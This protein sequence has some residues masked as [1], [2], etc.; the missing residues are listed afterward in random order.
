MAFNPFHRFRKHQKVW[1]AGLTIVCMIV[2][3]CTGFGGDVVSRFLGW[4]GANRSRGEVVTKLYGKEV[5]ESDLQD[6]ARQRTFANE[7]MR[8]AVFGGISQIRQELPKL[9]VSDPAF[10]DIIESVERRLQG[11]SDPRDFR[12]TLESNLSLFQRRIHEP[13]LPGEDPDSR[14]RVIESLATVLAEELWEQAVRQGKHRNEYYLGGFRRPASLLD[15][16]IWLHEAD[17]LGIVLTDA[18]VRRE[19]NR[20]AGNVGAQF[21]GKTFAED[22]RVRAFLGSQKNPNATPDKLMTALRDE[23]RVLL[24]QQAVLGQPGGQ[25][26]YRA[27]VLGVSVSPAVVTP[28]EYL[29]YFREQRTALKVAFLPVAVEHFLPEVKG[30]P[31]EQ[32]LENRYNEYKDREPAPSQR[33]P[34]FKIPRR[35]KYQYASVRMDSPFYQKEADLYLKYLDHLPHA[36]VAA[37]A[38][39]VVLGSP[40]GFAINASTPFAFDPIALSYE[41]YRSNLRF[42][43]S[44]D[45]GVGIDPRDKETR[46]ALT[47]GQMFAAGAA[48][49][50]PLA[51]PLAAPATRG[52]FDR[53]EVRAFATSVLAAG[54]RSPL[55]ALG[56]AMPALHVPQPYSV[57]R[58]RLRA[59]YQKDL[60]RTL[61]DQNLQALATEA[62]K[63]RNK[64]VEEAVKLMKEKCAQLHFSW[65]SMARPGSRYELDTDPALKPFR[66]AYEKD[67]EKAPNARDFASVLIKAPPSMEQVRKADLDKRRVDAMAISLM[68]QQKKP[69]FRLFQLAQQQKQEI[70]RRLQQGTEPGLFDVRV[71]PTGEG[72]HQE[73]FAFWRAEDRPAHVPSPGAARPEVIASWKFDQARALALR[74]TDRILAGLKKLDS[75]REAE[76][77]LTEQ[78]LGKVF[79]LDDIARLV[80]PKKEPQAVRQTEFRPYEI[81]RKDRD[82]F[83]YPPADLVDRLVSKLH[84]PGEAMV[85]RDEP[86]RHYY[87]AVLLERSEPSMAKFIDRYAKAP[88]SDSDFLWE[89]MMDK[90]RRDYT[91]RVLKQ[92]RIEAIGANGVDDEGNIKIPENLVKNLSGTGEAAD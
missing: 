19:I 85:V 33:E 65:H 1:F 22:P 52:L 7:F 72:Q 60:A 89:S 26:G 45:A 23:F 21:Q 20:A 92:L 55:S 17:R 73:I 58:S 75:P 14:A 80:E 90:A 77:F 48:P 68:R 86:V 67:T 47:L 3:V 56:L 12:N 2:F 79:T 6:L 64:S 30:E 34:G 35:F 5:K 37:I 59:E 51:L 40:A 11:F 9:K 46:A 42:D 66:E 78:K 71:L 81:P 74:D 54:T 13:P 28:D 91:L 32:D 18:D 29:R 25:P 27:Q 53:I 4:A 8:S 84:K 50:A 31:S 15:F 62:E 41:S 36:G 57:V 49:A 16:R 39:A 43:A 83:R 10:G 70:D 69:D 44:N 88:L 38:G 61:V 24:A 82:L 63:V 76:K 87:V